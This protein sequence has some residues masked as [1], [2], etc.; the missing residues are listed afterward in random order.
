MKQVNCHEFF[1]P[2]NP[3]CA[4]SN[5]HHLITLPDPPSCAEVFKIMITRPG[6]DHAWRVP[7]EVGFQMRLS[8]RGERV[9]KNLK[10]SVGI[11]NKEAVLV[12]FLWHERRSR[13][14]TTTFSCIE[15]ASAN[16]P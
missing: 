8:E 6:F 9:I 3:P 10:K 2:A 4:L 16:C 1:F 14:S 11:V 13:K 5:K 7:V 15:S 12:R